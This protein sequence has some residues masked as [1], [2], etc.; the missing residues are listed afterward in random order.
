MEAIATR[1]DAIAIR[2]EAIAIR[3]EAFATRLEAIAIRLEA[4]AIRLEAVATRLEARFENA[5]RHWLAKFAFVLT[6]ATKFERLCANQKCLSVLQ[7]DTG[8]R[9]VG[10]LLD[11]DEDRAP[12]EAV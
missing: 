7:V 12:L 2:L 8:Y 3:L 11:D 6:A 4:I 10:F 5:R 1:L 9:K